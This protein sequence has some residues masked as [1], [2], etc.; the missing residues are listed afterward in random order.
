MIDV[1]SARVARCA[2]HR[3]GNRVREEG[4]LLSEGEVRGTGD[5]HGTLLRNYLAPLAKSDDEFEFYHESDISLNALRR[6]SGNVFEDPASFLRQTQ[7]IAKSLYSASTHPQISGGEF[8]AILFNDVRVEG[9][10]IQSL[11]LY[12]IEAREPLFDLVQIKYRF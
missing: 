10:S 2:V 11:G 9:R 6:F 3:V 12:R 8:I 4:Y 1:S 7:N 5:L